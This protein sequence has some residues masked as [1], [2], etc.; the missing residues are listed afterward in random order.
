LII[1]IS[2]LPWIILES[3]KSNTSINYSVWFILLDSW[4]QFLTSRAMFNCCAYTQQMDS[5]IFWKSS[6]FS[7][8]DI[9]SQ[10]T[11]PTPQTLNPKPYNSC[12]ETNLTKV[13]FGK[14][15]IFYNNYR[16]YPFLLC[17]STNATS[18]LFIIPPL[19]NHGIFLD[20]SIHFSMVLMLTTFFINWKPPRFGL[21]Y[22]QTI[23]IL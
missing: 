21:F 2:Y 9:A 11:L 4:S 8:C 19:H 20:A 3:W 17:F 10:G 15:D 13:G 14:V 12:F 6:S 22:H 23:H 18:N 5:I 1:I 7:I 16:L